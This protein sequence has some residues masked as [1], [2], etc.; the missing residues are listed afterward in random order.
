[1]DASELESDLGDL[2]PLVT[3]DLRVGWHAKMVTSEM[4]QRRIKAASDRL[5]EARRSVEGLGQHTMSIDFDSYMYWDR[6]LPGCWKD[7][8]F[9][10]EFAKANPHVRVQSTSTTTVV[11]PGLANAN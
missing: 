6:E 7:K 2:A 11:N 3:E 10:E 8:A 9:R 5:A 4:R 1:L